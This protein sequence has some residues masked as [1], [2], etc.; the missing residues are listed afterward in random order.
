METNDTINELFQKFVDKTLT[1]EERERFYT[2]LMDL[3]NSAQ[4]KQLLN[5][6]WD[7]VKLT[8]NREEDDADKQITGKLDQKGEELDKYIVETAKR[9]YEIKTIIKKLTS[10]CWVYQT[11][12]E[13][14][15]LR[16]MPAYY[17]TEKSN[18]AL[19]FCCKPS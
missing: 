15:T 2:Y 13:L 9:F 10:G 3:D 17:P 18:N 19:E 1:S 16:F 4:I 7:Y 14:K 12:S 8:A 6:L 5:E 11:V